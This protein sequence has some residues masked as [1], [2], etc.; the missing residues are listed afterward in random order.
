MA[1]N[2]YLNCEYCSNQY[3]KY[4]LKQH[5]LRC[6]SKIEYDKN[7]IIK[8]N[9]N[10]K[11]EENYNKNIN[12]FENLPNEII[13][14]IVSYLIEGMKDEYCSYRRI[15]KQY[16]NICFTSKRIYNIVYP[17]YDQILI[18]KNNLKEERNKKICKSTAKSTYK[19]SEH[20]LED[21]I[22][23]DLYVNPHY[24]SSSPMKLYQIAD[25]LDYMF[26]KY[27]FKQ[28]HLNQLLNK[29]KCKK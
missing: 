8:I 1:N 24:R 13:K 17:S 29:K 2:I 19:L 6:K 20:E 5:L 21:L 25:V 12:R 14:I 10:K 26:E 27:R 9:C 22:P 11:F 23:Y 4:S 7:Q 16:L 3:R 18:F 15:Y 28:N